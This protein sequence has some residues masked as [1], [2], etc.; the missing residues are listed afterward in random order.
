MFGCKGSDESL[1]T[2]AGLN[3]NVVSVNLLKDALN[4]SKGVLTLTVDL[5]AEDRLELV[6]I[7]AHYYFLGLLLEC[8]LRDNFLLFG[9]TG[10]L[11]RHNLLL[12][13]CK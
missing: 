8:K 1:H 10:T 13:Y 9:L 12:N 11:L 5:F 3:F 6:F 7:S 4:G 2:T